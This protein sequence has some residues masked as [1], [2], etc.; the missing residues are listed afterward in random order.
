M[1]T[2]YFMLSIPALFTLPT[3]S[4]AS[5]FETL[6]QEIEST[7]QAEMDQNPKNPFTAFQTGPMLRNFK[8]MSYQADQIHKIEN[9]GCWCY[10]YDNHGPGKAEPVDEIDASCK[11]L[12]HGYECMMIDAADE[13]TS[14]S[15][16]NDP[17]GDCTSPWDVSYNK[18]NPTGLSPSEIVDSCFS[19][20]SHSHCAAR[21]CGIETT[22]IQNIVNLFWW[23]DVIHNGP[24]WPRNRNLGI[25]IWAS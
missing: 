14:S 12:H 11:I 20:N 9:Y 5:T 25:W 21:A 22:F 1:K 24:K 7:L 10:F 3:I 18:I 6:F 15:G 4:N 16:Y 19:E 13:Q 8:D 2:Q 17:E 23:E